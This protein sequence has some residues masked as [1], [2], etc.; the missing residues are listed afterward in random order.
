MQ[1][2]RQEARL[3]PD[4]AQFPEWA[5]GPHVQMR[6]RRTNMVRGIR[7]KGR[8]QVGKPDKRGGREGLSSLSR[9]APERCEAAVIRDLAT[10]KTK[11]EM[12]S[13]LHEHFS[14]LA[15]EIETAMKGKLSE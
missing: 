6:L 10:D 12:Y 11:R 5:H 2:L 7:R 15:D 3:G 8:C 4:Y 14:R 13:K 9:K 1:P